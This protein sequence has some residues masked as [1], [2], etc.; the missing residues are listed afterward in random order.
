MSFFMVCHCKIDV[1]F[2]F[3]YKNQ[4]QNFIDIFTLGKFVLKGHAIGFFSNTQLLEG[5]SEV[6]Y[7]YSMS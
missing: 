7:S 6:L 5:E 1:V 3:Y 2:I 4:I